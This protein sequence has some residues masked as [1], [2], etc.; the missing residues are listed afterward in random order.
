MCRRSGRSRPAGS[1]RRAGR[2]R[3][4][5]RGRVHAVAAT[6]KTAVAASSVKSPAKTASRAEHG[7]LGITK[8]IVAPVERRAQ[9]VAGAGGCCSY[10]SGQ[11]SEAI[12]EASI[13][14]PIERADAGGGELRVRAGCRRDG[15]KARRSEPAFRGQ[16]EVAG[17][18]CAGSTKSR[19]ESER[20]STMSS[21]LASATR[22]SGKPARPRHSAARGWSRETRDPRRRSAEV[23]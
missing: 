3:S 18:C 10:L 2:S 14:L 13:D 17:W 6:D 8:E 23:G 22:C 5:H 15:C 11:Q 16:G 7:T 9:R 20:Q 4:S 21:L 19:T 1:A 12:V